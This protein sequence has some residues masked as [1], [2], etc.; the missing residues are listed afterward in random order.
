M[1]DSVETCPA[2]PWSSVTRKKF[3]NHRVE[4]GKLF[5]AVAGA[6]IDAAKAGAEGDSS[7]ADDIIADGVAI[8]V[9]D[10]LEV[11]DVAHDERHGPLGAA[12]SFEGLGAALLEGAVVEQI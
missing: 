10:A 11:V 1:P 2:N 5:A 7:G 9:V 3:S 8:G 4:D 6:Q 12:R